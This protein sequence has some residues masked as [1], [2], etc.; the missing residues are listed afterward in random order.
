MFVGILSSDVCIYKA[1]QE[2]SKVKALKAQ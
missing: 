1:L 2:Q